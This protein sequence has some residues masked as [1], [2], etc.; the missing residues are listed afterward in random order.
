MRA[1]GYRDITMFFIPFFGAMV[2]AKPRE[3]IATW[4][5]AII[6]LA[7]P[8]PG[9]ILGLVILST[10]PTHQDVSGAFTWR[11]VGVMAAI[12]NLL[13]LLPITPLDGGRLLEISVFKR[14]PYTR[15]AFSFLSMAAV[16]GF[17]FYLN[18]WFLLAVAG[19]LLLAIRGQ[20]Q[21]ARLSAAHRPDLPEDKRIWA[22]FEKARATLRTKTFGQQYCLIKAAANAVQV[23]TTRLWETALIGLFMTVLW[24]GLGFMLYRDPPHRIVAAKQADARSE[25][26]KAFDKTFGY[27]QD[28]IDRTSKV[29]ELKILAAA[30]DPSDPRRVDAD[31]EEVQTLGQ[32]ERRKQLEALLLQGKNGFEHTIESMATTFLGHVYQE[33]LKG[34]PEQ[35]AAT[36]QED[37][38]RV[39]HLAPNAT[40]PITWA[41]LHQARAIDKTGNQAKALALLDALQKSA[42][43]FETNLI[44][45]AKAWFYISH[46]DANEALN[47]LER[48]FSVEHLS[49][50]H[51]TIKKDY[52]WALLFAGRLDEGVQHMHLA[53]YVAPALAAPEKE[54]ILTQPL[55]MAY[56]L[57]KAGRRGEARSLINEQ[58]N[59][60]CGS[61]SDELGFW[62]IP[63]QEPYYAA[64]NEAAALVC[65]QADRK[66][67]AAN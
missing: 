10:L 54:A 63:W 42:S 64:L 53:S 24:G 13:N 66:A 32:P 19:F 22:L 51:S 28:D 39:M 7:G 30:L 50:Q 9:L 6:L 37:I 43:G 18:D 41:R 46:G 25:Q 47:V 38:D 36:L 60:A 4:K 44:T 57:I 8:L 2:T 55:D 34:S 3:P 20:W 26:Q 1:F 67:D 58:T 21:I 35:A 15:L 62:D 49:I 23:R 5:E 56:A 29:N 11:D 12:L 14:W 48:S 40:A 52:A 27:Y 45:R 65:P 31:A 16:L 33:S 61:V 17:A 59:W